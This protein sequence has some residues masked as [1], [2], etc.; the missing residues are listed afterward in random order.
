M[1]GG[2]VE[3]R[4]RG[5]AA[6]VFIRPSSRRH[7]F[8]IRS[9]PIRNAVAIGGQC[10]VASSSSVHLTGQTEESMRLI[11]SN[12]PRRR[13]GAGTTLSVVVHAAAIVAAVAATTR[14]DTPAAHDMTPETIHFAPPPRHATASIEARDSRSGGAAAPVAGSVLAL[15]IPG[16]VVTIDP[17][18]TSSLDPSAGLIDTFNHGLSTGGER[19]TAGLS[20]GAPFDAATVD[21]AVLPI[22]TPRPRYP[23][24]LRAAGIEGRAVLRFVVDTL[25]RVEGGSATVV[26][27]THPAFGDAALAALP[28]MRFRPAEAGGRRVRQLVELPIDFVLK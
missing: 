3:A 2:P 4:Q 7:R 12:V 9:A 17:P 1:I 23:E 11:E 27:A 10:R 19:P 28:A 15:S 22:S 18:P 8:L 24:P 16:P 26:Q 21:R 6:T 5:D 14:A 25:G 20:S 13:A